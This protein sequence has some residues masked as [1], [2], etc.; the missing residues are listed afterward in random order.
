MGLATKQHT[1]TII[2]NEELTNAIVAKT[3]TGLTAIAK[4]RSVAN[5]GNS[6][7][8]LAINGRRIR[9]FL[10]DVSYGSGSAVCTAT[11]IDIDDDDKTE[12]AV[13]L[14]LGVDGWK[15]SAT[16]AHIGTAD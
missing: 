8:A 13:T 6:V 7:V 2:D 15:A 16:I 5:E 12:Y 11:A 3:G 14:K 4:G 9:S 1:V 10:D